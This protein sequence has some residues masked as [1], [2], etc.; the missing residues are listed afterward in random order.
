MNNLKS[1][2]ELQELITLEIKKTSNFPK[3]LDIYYAINYNRQKNFY[4]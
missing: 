2:D 4:I 1:I 3:S